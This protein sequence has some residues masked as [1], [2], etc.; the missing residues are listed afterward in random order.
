MSEP[1]PE[2]AKLQKAMV[3]GQVVGK[4]GDEDAGSKNELF[5]ILSSMYDV[6]GFVSRIFLLVSYNKEFEAII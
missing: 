3:R 1:E 5:A 4:F 2:P 6:A